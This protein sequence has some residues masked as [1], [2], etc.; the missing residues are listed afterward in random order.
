MK[1]ILIL[2]VPGHV[3]LWLSLL[4]WGGGKK[5]EKRKCIFLIYLIFQYLWIHNILGNSTFRV[6]KEIVWIAN[7]GTGNI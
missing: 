2:A 7:S 3:L 1:L 4:K 5:K 6:D